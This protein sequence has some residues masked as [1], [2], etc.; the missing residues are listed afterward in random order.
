MFLLSF[1]AINDADV[2]RQCLPL[3]GQV[4]VKEGENLKTRLG[5]E[6]ICLP[7]IYAITATYARPEQKAELVRLCSTFLHVKHFFWI[8]V[9]D[10]EEKTKLVANFLQE[11]GL[12][13]THLNIRTRPEFRLKKTDHR[14]KYPRGVDQ[15]NAAIQWLLDN[16]QMLPQGVVYFAD[17]DNT[18]SPQLF[19]EIL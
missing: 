19:K 13:Y 6:I 1:S 11:C 8:V 14:I 16:V 18:F 9:E 10:S 12:N 15:R 7:W 4:R 17:D 2:Y 5:G 3:R